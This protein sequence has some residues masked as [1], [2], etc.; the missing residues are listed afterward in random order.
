L[1][2][3]ANRHPRVNILQ[4][5]A[6]VGGHC[7]AVDPWFIVAG[8]PD[9]AH[10]VRTARNVNNAKPEWTLQKLR[11]AAES[12]TLAHEGR[13]PVI[14]IWRSMKR[15]RCP[16]IRSIPNAFSTVLSLAR[17]LPHSGGLLLS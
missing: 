5:G 16:N 13:K 15:R 6:G 2:R 17:S 9:L 14:V 12:F 7:I 8:A 10:L 1:I 4:H 3:L 11:T